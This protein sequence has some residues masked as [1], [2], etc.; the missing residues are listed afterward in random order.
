MHYYCKVGSNKPVNL[1]SKISKKIRAVVYVFK[2]QFL[3]FLKI[4]VSEKIYKN[5]CNVI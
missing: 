2:Q 3:V 1:L 5:I 4:Y